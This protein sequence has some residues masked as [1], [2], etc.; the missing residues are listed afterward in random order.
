[1]PYTPQTW[2]DDS[3]PGT[4]TL[5]D[6]AHFN[7]IES[8]ISAAVAKDEVIAAA[9][10]ILASKLSS[11]DAQPAFRVLGDGRHE[12]GPGASTTP[13]VTL[14]RS[15][16]GILQLGLSNQRG[17]LKVNGQ[18]AGDVTFETLVG[19]DA[20]SRLWVTAGGKIEMGPGNLTP[21]V[22]LYRKS[23]DQLATDDQLY[24]G[25][26]LVVDFE[27]S[28]QS[29]FFG[30]A[31]DTNLYREA[32]NRLA[33]DDSMVIYG[34]LALGTQ[35]PGAAGSLTFGDGTT[36]TTAAS[37]GLQAGT[38]AIWF[39]D[40]APSG[41][42]L[43]DGS[44]LTNAQTNYPALWANIASA[45]KSGSDII[46]P[47]L[48]GRMPVGKGTNTDVDTLGKNEGHSAAA[49]VNRRPKH[50][51]LVSESAHNH[52]VNDPTH[53]HSV[54]DP[55]HVNYLCYNLGGEAW[56]FGLEQN[57]NGGN[58]AWTNYSATGIGIYGAATGITLNAASTGLTVGPQTQATWDTPAYIAV[59]WIIK[60]S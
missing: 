14:Q 36:Q 49:V 11:G 23:S 28:Q 8:G 35:T 25:K 45:W 50:P 15:A 20:F 29:L 5:L 24:V 21:D 31:M 30:T 58:E 18:T 19:S 2:V 37:S 44:T 27:G 1:M 55:T 39:S 10:R 46:L 42:A 57:G 3:P 4:G 47:D 16:A 12:W 54:Y 17:R 22:N 48:R 6:A 41:W 26:R 40:T 59:N 38:G 9:T 43:C 60:L 7:Y 56:R 52:G 33:T 34:G 13:D 53:A 51:H 32:A